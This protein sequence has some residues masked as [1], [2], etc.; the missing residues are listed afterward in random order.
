MTPELRAMAAAEFDRVLSIDVSEQ[1][2][3]LYAC[4][5]AP[6]ARR[7]ERV[8]RADWLQLADFVDPGSVDAV[9][10]DGA[11]GNVSLPGHTR[12]L[13]QVSAVLRPGGRLVP[14]QA[15]VPHGL[16][17]AD[18][19]WQRLRDRFRAGELDMVWHADRQLSPAATRLVELAAE[20]CAELS[21]GWS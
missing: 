17:V 1:A 3:A 9:L 5:L 20:V 4:W 11:F 15:L 19:R 10:G 2:I 13:A 6:E 7:R 8:L 16:A 14:R 21:W 12:L 18:N